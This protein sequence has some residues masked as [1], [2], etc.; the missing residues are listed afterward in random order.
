MARMLA[1]GATGSDVRALQDVLNYHIRRGDPLVVDGIF[2]PR[3]EARAREFQT[4]NG[5]KPDGLVGPLTQALLYEVTE[6]TIPLLFLPRLELDRPS[7]GSDG[8]GG[9]QPPRL[10]PP[11]RWSGPPLPPLGSFS[12]GSSFRLSPNGIAG[13]PAF[14]SPV[15]ALGFKLRVPTR[16]DPLDPSVRSYRNIIALIDDLPIDS[17]LRVFLT[18]K[19]PN[20]VKTISPP[21]TGFDWGVQPLFNPLDPTGFGAKGNA[22]FTVRVSEGR[23]GRPNLVF[24]AWGDGRVFLDFSK[25]QGQARP[26]VS[27]EGQIFLGAMGVF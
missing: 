12:F 1:R 24:G 11:L 9:L 17:K 16:Q 4:A 21:G 7:L 14:S 5:L 26:K 10:I 18:S 20:P 19:V 27:G 15:N 8:P 3:T 23:D 13:L 22:R 6:V 2:G 25:K